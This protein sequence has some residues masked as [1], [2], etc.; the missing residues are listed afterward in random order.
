MSDQ[1]QPAEAE[2]DLWCIEAE[3]RNAVI[4]R[5]NVLIG[6]WAGRLMGKN[7]HALTAYAREVHY[8]DFEVPG[9]SDVIAKLGTDFAATGHS[10]VTATLRKQLASF[11]KQAWSECC[12][13]D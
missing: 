11:G 8:A 7:G 3:T 6:L 13:T 5:R 9:D 12:A 2:T 1:T 4:A 10:V